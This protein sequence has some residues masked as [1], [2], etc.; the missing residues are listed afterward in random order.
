MAKLNIKHLVEKVINNSGI[1]EYLDSNNGI[2]LLRYFSQS[3]EDK[4]NELIYEYSYLIPSFI[5]NAYEEGTIDDEDYQKLSEY[6]KESDEYSLAEDF[7][8]GELEHLKKPL[9]NYIEAHI[10]HGGIEN[11]P[12]SYTIENGK[13]FKNGWIIHFTS[14]AL[15]IAREGFRYGTDDVS[16]LAY[17]GAGSTDGK[18]EGYNFGYDINDFD[19]FYRGYSGRPKY[20]SEAVLCQV[21]GVKVWHYGDEEYQ[22]I[23]WGKDAKNI[24]PIV[25][26]DGYWKI[27]STKTG[28]KLIEFE[29]L[30]DIVDWVMTNKEQYRKHLTYNVKKEEKNMKKYTLTESELK[31]FVSKIVQEALDEKIYGDGKDS[32]TSYKTGGYGGVNQHRGNRGRFDAIRGDKPEYYSGLPIPTET[33]LYSPEKM[34]FFKAKHFGANADNVESSLSIFQDIGEMGWEMNNLQSATKGNIQWKAITDDPEATVT[35]S[36]TIKGRH[37]FWL[38]KLPGDTDWRLFKVNMTKR[39][40]SDYNPTSIKRVNR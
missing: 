37:V 17:T 13:L 24:I 35:P 11:A 19:R 38:V 16:R 3:D 10:Y 34:K 6:L 30:S 12:A 36:G 32:M 26:E 25:E 14:D 4:A 22:V 15:S 5:E 9:L 20:G 18:A 29:N 28:N 39:Y 2:P 27:L 7:A 31:E 21:S 1:D 23:F 33:E 40:N 8:N